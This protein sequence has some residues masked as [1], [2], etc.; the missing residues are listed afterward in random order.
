MT[1][2]T[3][4]RM[5]AVLTA[6]LLVNAVV[7]GLCVAQGPP[8]PSDRPMRGEAMERGPM[9]H[10]M[11]G[12]GDGVALLLDKQIALQL[13]A[14][15]VNQLI[16]IH[17]QERQQARPLIARLEGLMPKDRDGWRNMTAAQRDSLGSIH[18]ALR[19]I[20]WRQVSAASAVL[21]DDQKRIAAKLMD[22]GGRKGWKKDMKDGTRDGAPHDH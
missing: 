4:I 15:Q 13:T 14:A 8:A 11:R 21:N 17:Q 9:R 16:T 10:R 1:R 3:F 2:F 20:Q 18:E 6:G 12:E 19:E 5:P 7:V 22:R